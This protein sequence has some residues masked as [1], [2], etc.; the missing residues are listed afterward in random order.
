MQYLFLRKIRSLVGMVLFISTQ[1]SLDG[2]AE[3]SI[4]FTL[5]PNGS[6]LESGSIL[7]SDFCDSTK[8]TLGESAC[9]VVT[10]D[11]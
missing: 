10:N 11:R 3:T 4:C 6:Y 2:P 7:S 5:E 8:S 9:S 1:N